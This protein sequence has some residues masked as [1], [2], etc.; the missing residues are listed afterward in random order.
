MNKSFFL[1]PKNFRMVFIWSNHTKEKLAQR[2]VESVG[3][4]A[5]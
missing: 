3:R 2:M 1:C 4:F 5:K